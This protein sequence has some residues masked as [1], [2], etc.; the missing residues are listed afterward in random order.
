MDERPEAGFFK[1]QLMAG[2]GEPMKKVYWVSA[3]CFCEKCEEKN[4]FDFQNA[5]PSRLVGQWVRSSLTR[6]ALPGHEKHYRICS[7]Y[8]V[9]LRNTR[10]FNLFSI[11]L[12]IKES[13]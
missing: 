8:S 4:S 13:R 11:F 2:L 5:K 3:T 6:E 12:L 7:V 10:S 1:E 9:I